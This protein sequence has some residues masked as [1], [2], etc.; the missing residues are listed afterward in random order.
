MTKINPI[1]LV[2]KQ[3]KRMLLVIAIGIVG[4]F[5]FVLF[6]VK[7]EEKQDTHSALVTR[8]PTLIP[9]IHISQPNVNTSAWMTYSDPVLHYSIKYPSTVM[10]DPGEPFSTAFIFK[11]KD[12]HMLPRNSR[13]YEALTIETRSTKIESVTAMLAEHNDMYVSQIQLNNAYGFGSLDEANSRLYLTDSKS[14]GEYI[15]LAIQR[16]L[17]DDHTKIA[18]L[19]QM[20]RTFQCTR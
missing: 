18:I 6:L 3:R 5:L 8:I 19:K 4:V 13:N 20:V 17:G 9:V 16:Y 12:W 2:I 14:N 7:K 10:L 1:I 15:I 11:D